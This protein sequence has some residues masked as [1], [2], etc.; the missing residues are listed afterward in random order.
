MKKVIK[1]T[2]GNKWIQF[3]KNSWKEKEARMTEIAK[4][5]PEIHWEILKYSNNKTKK[6][7]LLKYPEYKEFINK[8]R[9]V[10]N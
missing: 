4:G 8:I 10:W 1:L 3:V 9:G 2:A 7:V 5:I 6:E